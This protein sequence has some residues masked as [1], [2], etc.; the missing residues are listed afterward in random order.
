MKTMNNFLQWLALNGLM[1]RYWR[2]VDYACHESDVT[3]L[4]FISQMD[5]NNPDTLFDVLVNANFSYF[6][7][8][9]EK[10]SNWLEGGNDV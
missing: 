5:A 4:S 10:Y 7:G 9:K 6:E 1:L 8:M 3:T 2:V